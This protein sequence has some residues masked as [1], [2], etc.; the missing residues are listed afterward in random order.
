M[1]RRRVKVDLHVHTR[2]SS[3][4]LTS[5]REVVRYAR[6]RGLDAVAITDHNTIDGA[7]L[8]AEQSAVPVII[9]EE[10]LTQHGEIIG[11]FLQ[12][13]VP[14]GLSSQETVLR[15]REQGGLVY[16]PHPMDRMRKS[17][18]DLEALIAAIEDVDL[19]EV[20]NARVTLTQDNR[21]AESLA[22]AYHTAQGAGSDAHQAYEIGSA[23][24]ELPPFHD[25]ASF[26]QAMR[27]GQV[28]GHISLPLVHIG[29]TYA[30]V[31]KELRAFSLFR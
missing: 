2:F 27:Q 23:Y 12:E 16:I 22:R 1:E 31:A 5:Q 26:M 19:I 15:I 29:S 9:G 17:A 24:V 18:L 20:F 3:D 28:H 13:A 25:S 6:R 8:L 4:S 30:K 11:L 7:L 21:L 14:A 10:I